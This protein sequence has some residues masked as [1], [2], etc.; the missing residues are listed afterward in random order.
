MPSTIHT[1]QGVA[2]RL[3]EMADEMT[4][5]ANPLEHLCDDTLLNELRKHLRHAREIAEEMTR[6]RVPQDDE[7]GDP[8]VPSDH[9]DPLPF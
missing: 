3:Q 1:V 9:D 6:R 7:P 4:G 8:F 2:L 5:P